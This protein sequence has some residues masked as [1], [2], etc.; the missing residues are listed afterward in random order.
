MVPAGQRTP[1]LSRR[2]DEALGYL[3]IHRLYRASGTGRP[4]FRHLTQPFLVGGYRS[5]LL[6][7]LQGIAD[8]DP[9]LIRED[10]VQAA[11][12]DMRQLAPDGRVVRARNYG[13]KLIDPVPF[14]PLGEP[15]RFL[16]WQWTLIQRTF[17]AAAPLVTAPPGTAR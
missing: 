4:L 6:D 9:A 8:A 10:W 13:R 14:E 2:L 12:D 17:S 7:M 1:Q 15:S 3:R 16:T 5:G 11:V